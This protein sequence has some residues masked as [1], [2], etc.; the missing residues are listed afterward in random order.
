[1]RVIIPLPL[2]HGTSA[3]SIHDG[4]E[5]TSGKT[6][7]LIG[8]AQRYSLLAQRR[9]RVPA[10]DE[11]IGS[12]PIGAI[13]NDSCE[14]IIRDTTC[15]NCYKIFILW[16][17]KQRRNSPFELRAMNEWNKQASKENGIIIYF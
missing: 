16:L 12:I 2:S 8:H 15:N 17:N 1:M 11:A 7:V 14:H 9:E 6:S 5:K 10:K 13:M 4:G 3:I